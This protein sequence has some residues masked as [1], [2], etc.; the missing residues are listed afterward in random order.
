MV[1]LLILCVMAAV[2]VAASVRVVPEGARLATWRLGRYS[3]LRGAGLHL[4]LPGID[5]AAVIGEGDEGEMRTETS[6]SVK[7]AEV[8]VASAGDLTRGQP[9]VVQGFSS[10]RVVVVPRQI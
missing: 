10:D 4:V 5:R 6:A 3:G 2:L 9:V 8:P 1:P 7:G